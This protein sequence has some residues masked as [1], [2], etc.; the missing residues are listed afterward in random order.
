MAR[1]IKSASII[2]GAT[3]QIKDNSMSYSNGIETGSMPTLYNKDGQFVEIVNLWFL[4]LKTVKRLEDIS[5]S[6]RAILRYWSFLERE[7]LEWNQFPPVKRL[8]PTYRFRSNDLLNAVR[9]GVLAFSTANTYMGH[10][11]QFYLWA[12]ENHHLIISNEK[13]APFTIEFVKR[14][15]NGLLAHLR[16]MISVQTSD[17]RIRVPKVSNTEAQSLTPLS[18]DHLTLL[19]SNLSHQSIEFML[20]SLLACKSGLRL[21]EACTLTIEALSQALPANELKLR[22]M[23]TIGPHNGVETK[24]RKKRKIEVP[25]TLLNA[26]QRYSLSERRQKRLSKLQTKIATQK[27]SNVPISE[28][29]KESNNKASRFEPLFISQQGN[30]IQPE[31]LN[32]RWVAFRNELAKKV[33][34]FRYRFHDLRC[35]YA[36]YRLQDLLDSNLSEGEA[37]DCL[38]GWMGHNNE[39]TTFK[40][41]RY[42]KK[43]EMLKC[44]FSLLDSVMDNAIREN[45][46]DY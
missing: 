38:M 30:C 40:Y 31:V 1:I 32:A 14:N 9:E 22:F 4:D 6:T 44:A 42:L 25:W 20:M 7:G 24:F 36:T 29:N 26:L 2:H 13:E 15:N 11:V 3:A 19:S 18:Q 17:L 37:L 27:T 33:P 23:I 10:V 12:I 34:S 5:S 43:N 45:L 16:P 39:R 35:T 28:K 41:I 21:R 8:K 46:D